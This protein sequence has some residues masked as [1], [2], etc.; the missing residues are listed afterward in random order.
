MANQRRSDKPSLRHR[1]FVVADW[2]PLSREVSHKQQS[3]DVMQVYEIYSSCSVDSLIITGVSD[4]L[5]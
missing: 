4:V 2:I 5:W 1:S 3:E